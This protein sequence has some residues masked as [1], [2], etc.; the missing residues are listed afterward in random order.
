MRDRSILAAIWR[1][2][3]AGAGA[4]ALFVPVAA[5]APAL[6]MLDGLDH[7]LWEVRFRDGEPTRKLC[8]RTG[9]ELIQLRHTD[10]NCSRYVVQDDPGEVT[11]QYTCRGN[12]Y[13]RTSIRR[14]TSSLVQIEGQEI[15]GDLPFQFKAEAR[16]IGRCAP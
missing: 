1:I 13:G 7:G 6:A 4:G 16:H 11:V 12:G 8:L 3:L 10:A 5:Q 15:V 14:E 2:G 9:R